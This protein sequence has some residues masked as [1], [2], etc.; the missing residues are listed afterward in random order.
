M[1]RV[2]A[3]DRLTIATRLRQFSSTQAEERHVTI[4]KRIATFTF[5]LMAALGGGAVAASPA[6][7]AW[8]GCSSGNNCFYGLSGG[9]G[10]PYQSDASGWPDNTCITLPVAWRNFASS[11][12]N[13]A[14]NT[15]IRY[16]ALT[17]CQGGA[18]VV[19]WGGG[20]VSL[21]GNLNNN[22]ESH[23]VVTN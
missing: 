15:Y 18:I 1:P 8:G 6:Y 22:N 7:A 21:S 16:F 13:H 9:A 10:T 3:V 4:R 11:I 23:D 14:P 19:L 12:Y 17:G 20:H 5:A 2:E